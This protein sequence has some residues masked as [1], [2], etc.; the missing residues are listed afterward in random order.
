ML[1]PLLYIKKSCE[2]I[3]DTS[4]HPNLR[5]EHFRLTKQGKTIALSKHNRL[6]F[7]QIIKNYTPMV[8]LSNDNP[9]NPKISP[10]LTTTKPTDGKEIIGN[11]L[12]FWTEHIIYI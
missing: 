9:T 2:T 10:N 11:F 1:Y 7:I 12:N 3:G 4:Y 5:Q 8:T 6:D